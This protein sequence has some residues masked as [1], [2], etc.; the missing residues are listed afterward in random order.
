MK[1]E[2]ASIPGSSRPKD[3]EGSFVEDGFTI[4][5]KAIRLELIEE[6]QRTINKVLIELADNFNIKVSSNINEEQFFNMEIL[7]LVKHETPFELL[8][9]VWRNLSAKGIP[10]KIFLERKIY[11]F[12]VN[13]LGKDICHQD[14]P[15]LT[16]N[17]PGLSSSNKNYL[18][19]AFHQEV[20]SGAN[21]N[22]I[23]FWTPIFKSKDSGGLVCVPGSHLWGH[24]PHKN[25][26]PIELPK[27]V[28][29][30]YANL[31]IGDV[32]IFHPL[33]LH[34]SKSIDDQ[35]TPTLAMPCLL[36][37]FRSQD[38][39]FECFKN[40]WNFSYSDLSEI[41]RRLGNHHLSPF[42]LL[43]I[44]NVNFDRSIN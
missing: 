27:G 36:K 38:Q 35:G 37:N 42:R 41:D 32:I 18:F 12:I 11:E 13:I 7:N 5:R 39:S 14:D 3:E 2:R 23:Q 19:K 30:Y 33:L 6:A 4:I 21:V 17:L 34:R 10:E 31:Q 28:R 43:D 24:I 40:L 25:R 1:K 22:T 26:K 8:M 9:P 16:L 15:S 29:Q 44:D 20:W